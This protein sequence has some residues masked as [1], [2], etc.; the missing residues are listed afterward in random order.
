MGKTWTPLMQV[1]EDCRLQQKD[2]KGEGLQNISRLMR[3]TMTLTFT[4]AVKLRDK[5]IKKATE[6]GTLTSDYEITTDLLL[7]HTAFITLELTKKLKDCKDNK[8]EI[9]KEIDDTITGLNNEEAIKLLHQTIDVLIKDKEKYIYVESI[10]NYCLALLQL[11]PDKIT[12]VDAYNNLIAA[13][14]LN[15]DYKSVISLY[16]MIEVQVLSIKDIYRQS[17]FYGN[18]ASAYYYLGMYT[19]CEYILKKISR[20][21]SLDKEIFFMTIDAACKVSNNRHKEAEKIYK[22]ILN[23]CQYTDNKDYKINTYA[24]LSDTYLNLNNIE[25]AIENINI[26]VDL[27]DNTVSSKVCYNV[28]LNLLLLYIIKNDKSKIE[29]AFKLAFNESLKLNNSSYPKRILTEMINYYVNNKCLDDLF[30]L[31]K[32][33]ETIQEDSI[34][35][36]LIRII[37]KNESLYNILNVLKTT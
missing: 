2:I 26:A 10:Q 28:Y 33:V 8:G 25:L 35:M 3:G 12:L 16:K 7:G 29:E 19:Q 34:S 18:V 32:Y 11:D 27:I 30:E 9:L 20:F 36:N 14:C 21:E 24:S 37:S 5:I 23:K 22:S 13:Y 17:C 31:S 15:N 4:T 1:L 6:K